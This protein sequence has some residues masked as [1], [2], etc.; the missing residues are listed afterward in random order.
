MADIDLK[1]GQTTTDQRLDLVFHK[2]PRSLA[3]P[4]REVME[5]TKPRSYTWKGGPVVDQGNEGACVGFGW[6]G[7]IMARPHAC[8]PPADPNR[9]AH[10]LYKAAQQIDAYPGDD[11]S[12]TDVIAGAKMLQQWG[13]VTEYRWA[14]GLDDVVLAL[15]YKGPVVLGINWYASMYNAPGGVVTVSGAKVGGHCILARGVNVKARTVLLRNSWGSD[16]G[17]GGDAVISFDDLGR[18]LAEDGEACVP[19]HRKATLA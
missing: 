3:Y 19:I 11:Y 17:N 13:I 16:W 10:D 1:G 5:A 15:G 12:G 14:M 2:D 7:D 6:T 18:L 9:Y 8:T 4:V